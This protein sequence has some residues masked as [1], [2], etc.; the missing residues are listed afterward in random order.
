MALGMTLSSVKSKRKN[1]LLLSLVLL[2][3]LPKIQHHLGQK[4][5]AETAVYFNLSKREENE[6]WK[7][8]F[9]PGVQFQEIS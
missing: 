3:M 7:Y 8:I 9:N 1:N 2:V 4:G 6:F 5:K